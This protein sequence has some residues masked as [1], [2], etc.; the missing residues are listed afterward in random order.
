MA[1]IK[2][3][4]GGTH[5][6]HLGINKETQEVEIVYDPKLKAAV[7]AALL[8]DMACPECGNKLEHT[9]NENLDDLTI[10]CGQCGK[11][12]GPPK[13]YGVV[14]QYKSL[15]DYFGTRT[16]G[17]V[18]EV[19][20]EQAIPEVKCEDGTVI[21]PNALY[22]GPGKMLFECVTDKPEN[23]PGRTCIEVGAFLMQIMPLGYNEPET[24]PWPA[25][26]KAE[27]GTDEEKRLNGLDL[28]KFDFTERKPIHGVDLGVLLPSDLDALAKK[29]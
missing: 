3:W 12:F 1:K 2:L 25:F 5:L 15:L 16:P 4:H 11:P 20:K 18:Y 27:V 22:F 23:Y 6:G 13:R 26:K 21:P 19:I 7:I 10:Y 17:Y 14:P 9:T 29:E 28:K 24:L 8:H